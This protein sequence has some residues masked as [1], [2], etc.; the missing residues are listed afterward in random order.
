MLDRRTRQLG[1][2]MIET[3]LSK[4]ADAQV[5]APTALAPK[6]PEELESAQSPTAKAV[7]PKVLTVPV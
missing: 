7:L 2:Q 6:K 1:V 3:A 4:L 5:I